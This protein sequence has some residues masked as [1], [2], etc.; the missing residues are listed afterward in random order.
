MSNLSCSPAVSCHASSSPRRRAGASPAIGVSA[1]LMVA[2]AAGLLAA[3]GG[4]TKRVTIGIPPGLAEDQAA[5]LTSAVDTAT[6]AYANKDDEEALLAYQ[7]AVIE[8]REL[9]QAW[10]N[11]GVLMMKQER[12]LEAAEA[13]NT[14]ASLSPQDARPVY[15]LGLLYD[16]RGYLRDAR[17]HYE[18]ALDRDP[19]YLPAL[20]GA[21]R[22]DSLLNEGSMQTLDWLKRAVMLEQDENWLAWMRLQKARIENLPAIKAQSQF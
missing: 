9:P 16:R 14:A 22:A 20:R 11:L 21:I 8:Y 12:Y 17:R 19:N 3:L 10:N 4:C 2:F 5:R 18:Q 15:N 13:L 6:E 1:A 7:R